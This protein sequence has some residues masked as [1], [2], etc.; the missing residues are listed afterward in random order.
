MATTE[1]MTR[2]ETVRRTID[3]C[4]CD[5]CGD[6]IQVG[7]TAHHL[8][9]FSRTYC[10]PACAEHDAQDEG[11]GNGGTVGAMNFAYAEAA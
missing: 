2:P 5:Y 4:Q 9:D 1:T 3:E 7:D 11:W 10:R 6:L 8:A